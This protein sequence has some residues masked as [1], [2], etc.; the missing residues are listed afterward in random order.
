MIFTD[1]NF[2]DYY[3]Q[4][5]V[6]EADALT[7]RLGNSL[8]I[9]EDDCFVLCSSFVA[10]T[11][12]LMFNVLSVGE[13]WENCERGLARKQMLGSYIPL[14]LA[15]AEVKLIRPSRKMIQKNLN[16]I[17]HVE[18]WAGEDLLE[19]R[20]DKRLD[21]IRDNCYPDHV[22]VGVVSDRGI[23]EY[24]MRVLGF[25]GPFIE[26]RLIALKK[27]EGSLRDEELV[28][29]LPYMMDGEYRLLAVFVGDHLSQEQ[30]KQFQD[31]VA[32]GNKI[33]FG[34]S[35]PEILRS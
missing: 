14:E 32:E 18:S 35:L 8:R 5:A 1:L 25:N 30:K 10:R 2:R 31:L 3:H 33:G 34:F 13:G 12:E 16:W 4:Y 15:D 21:D 26:G 22:K 7:E 24:E 19:T 17:N 27:N 11:G 6:F 29:A 9:S 20:R 28:R 23:H